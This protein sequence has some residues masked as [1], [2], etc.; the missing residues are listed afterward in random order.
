MRCLG[1]YKIIFFLLCSLIGFCRWNKFVDSC[2][3]NI[4]VVSG[5]IRKVFWNVFVIDNKFKGFKRLV[6]IYDIGW[7]SFYKLNFVLLELYWFGCIVLLNDLRFCRRIKNKCKKYIWLFFRYFNWS[8]LVI[9]YLI[10]VGY[11]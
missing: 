4:L 5:M 1:I 9:V 10:F 2:N 6:F 7:K 3:I 8:L 11:L